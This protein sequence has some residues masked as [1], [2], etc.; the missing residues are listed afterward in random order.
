MNTCVADSRNI[1]MR[2]PKSNIR[3]LHKGVLKL[4]LIFAI[5]HFP[6]ERRGKW[7]KVL[8]YSVSIILP[9]GLDGYKTWTL[10][11]QIVSRWQRSPV[12]VQQDGYET[13]GSMA[14]IANVTKTQYQ[15][16]L[17]RVEPLTLWIWMDGEC[18]AY[19]HLHL[20]FGPIELFLYPR[21]QIHNHS[22]L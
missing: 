7:W 22:S 18:L 5:R 8:I 12:T 15:Y 2:N 21:L 19:I 20:P 14:L 9:V 16:D 3:L 11:G 4:G 13:N 1:G 17:G 10:W 6:G